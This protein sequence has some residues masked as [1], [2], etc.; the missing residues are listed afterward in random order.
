M[1]F[2]HGGVA[3][4]SLFAEIESLQS[5]MNPEMSYVFQAQVVAA[6]VRIN[7]KRRWFFFRAVQLHILY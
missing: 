6:K 1:V 2:N 4:N 7:E 3:E 5:N